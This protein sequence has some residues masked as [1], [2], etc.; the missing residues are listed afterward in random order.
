LEKGS[1]VAFRSYNYVMPCFQQIANQRNA[2]GGVTKPPVKRGNQYMEFFFYCDQIFLFSGLKMA[3]NKV[4]RK[5]DLLATA[6][7][8][9]KKVASSLRKGDL[10]QRTCKVLLKLPG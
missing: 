1:H 7:R 3:I 5:Y 10:N 6:E 9:K 8:S 2:T 4:K